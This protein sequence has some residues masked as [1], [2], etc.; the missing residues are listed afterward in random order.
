[1]TASPVRLSRKSF[2][3][4]AKGK[5]FARF[6]DDPR[7]PLDEVLLFF[8][9]PDRQRR[10][11]ESEIHHDRSPLAGVVRELEARAAFERCLANAQTAVAKRLRVAVRIAVRM[12]MNGHQW[13]RSGRRSSMGVRSSSGAEVTPHNT[14][15]LAF[16]FL[17]AERYRCKAGMPFRSVHERSSEALKASQTPASLRT[18]SDLEARADAD[19]DRLRE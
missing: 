5:E 16:W 19:D 9:D 15:G 3:T 4:D 14:E 11:I 2:L 6:A 12:V 1:M 17:R 18:A 13:E 8:S 10:M 7:F